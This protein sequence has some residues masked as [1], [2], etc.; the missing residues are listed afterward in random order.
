TANVLSRA[1]YSRGILF[2]RGQFSLKRRHRM[3]GEITCRFQGR[4]KI[5]PV[6]TV[7]THRREKLETEV[8]QSPCRR[9]H[10]WPTTLPQRSQRGPQAAGEIPQPVADPTANDGI[11]Q[12]A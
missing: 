3:P 6:G 10:A 4:Q 7:V 12:S 8:Q 2:D 5:A 9:R 1:R 11:E